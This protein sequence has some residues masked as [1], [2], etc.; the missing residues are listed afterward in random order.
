MY[1]YVYFLLKK[2]FKIIITHTLI[3]RETIWGRKAIPL[4]EVAFLGV[5][6]D[7]MQRYMNTNTVYAKDRII[8][9]L[10]GD[11]LMSFNPKL[12]YEENSFFKIYG[13]EKEQLHWKKLDSEIISYL[14]AKCTYAFEQKR[15]ITLLRKVCFMDALKKISLFFACLVP[16]IPVIF[17][18]LYMQP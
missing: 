5:G 9:L 8:H 14:E 17:Y 1:T 11:T 2:N 18:E 6:D 3:I 15:K 4:Y 16:I 10:H 13:N 7:Y 12:F